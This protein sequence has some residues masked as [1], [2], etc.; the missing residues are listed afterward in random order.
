MSNKLEKPD[1]EDQLSARVKSMLRFFSP[2][3]DM[4]TAERVR[5]VMAEGYTPEHDDQHTDESLAMAAAYFAWPFFYLHPVS[6]QSHNYPNAIYAT[7]LCP[8]SWAREHDKKTKQDRIRQLTIAGAL[9]AAEIDRLV[10]AG[11]EDKL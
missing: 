2:G 8:A 11:E 6:D 1:T 3:I 5:Q 7:H 10:R 4:I 9:L